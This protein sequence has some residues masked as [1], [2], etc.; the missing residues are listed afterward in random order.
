M[1]LFRK[2]APE[3]TMESIMAEYGGNPNIENLEKLLVK[4]LTG[5]YGN[6]ASLPALKELQAKERI[7]HFSDQVIECLLTDEVVLG[8]IQADH[9]DEKN[10][11]RIIVDGFKP[12]KK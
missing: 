8:A 3:K 12:K 10:W 11:I 4:D 2:K 7:D 6:R 5:I 1:G 9:E